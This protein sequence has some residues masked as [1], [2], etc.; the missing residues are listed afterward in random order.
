[1]KCVVYLGDFDLRNEN[2]QAHL[3]KNN[4]KIFNN[5][6]FAVAY[7]GVNRDICSFS[8]IDKLPAFEL[9]VNMYLELPNTLNLSGLLKYGR[10]SEKIFTY[11][12]ALIK[13]YNIQYV[14]S[15]QSPTYALILKKIARW[16]IN[17]NVVYIVNCADIPIFDSQ[18]FIKRIV[19]SLNWRILHKINY[20]YAN[21]LISVSHYIE[22]FY[23]KEGRRSIVIPPLFDDFIDICIEHSNEL[24]TFLYAGIPF[25]TLDR[26]VNVSGMKDRLDKVIDIFR[27]LSSKGINYRFNIIGLTKETYSTCVPRHKAFLEKNTDIVFWGRCSH[28]DTLKQVKKS[29]FM[30]NYRDKNK[31]T[32]AGLSTKVVESVSLGTPVVMNSIGDTFKYLDKGISGFELLG[33]MDEDVRVMTQLC[34]TDANYRLLLKKKC[35]SLQVFSIN[36]YQKSMYDFLIGLKQ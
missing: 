31:M 23:Y 16:C 8:E 26:E 24:P 11:L 20:H 3:V 18:P 36:K 34:N 1:M 10:L 33:D 13:E 32:E 12:Q 25:I 30:I 22:N 17:N 6:D 9:G 15:Y 19:M 28:S 14:I 27:E 5:L 21:A 35:Y 4:A 2:V 29:D 7:I